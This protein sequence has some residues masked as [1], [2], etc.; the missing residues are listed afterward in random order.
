MFVCILGGSWD[1]A[2]QKLRKDS[3]ETKDEAWVGA[4]VMGEKGS[5]LI[6]TDIARLGIFEE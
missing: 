3:R 2:R 6:G 5:V 1:G 4:G